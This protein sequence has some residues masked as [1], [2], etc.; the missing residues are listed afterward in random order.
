MATL[1]SKI[2][3]KITFPF[4]LKVYELDRYEC[5]Y[6]GKSVSRKVSGVVK[7]RTVDHLSPIS[8]MIGLPV[9]VINSLSNLVTA[10]QTCNAKLGDSPIDKKNPQYGR[11]RKIV[12]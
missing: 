5:V 1:S 3:Q 10:H 4:K 2:R 6:C 8:D 9:Q 11:F 12:D 7:N